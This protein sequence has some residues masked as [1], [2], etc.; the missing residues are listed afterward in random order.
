MSKA[1]GIET[2]ETAIKKEMIS[3]IDTETTG[4]TT[5]MTLKETRKI[6]SLKEKM[7]TRKKKNDLENLTIR[8]TVATSLNSIGNTIKLR[9]AVKSPE[10]A[11]KNL[12]I[13]AISHVIDVKSL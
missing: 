8:P 7:T 12:E 4:G 9:N 6:P 5:N 10:K 2:I 13:R 3:V 1:A 11:V